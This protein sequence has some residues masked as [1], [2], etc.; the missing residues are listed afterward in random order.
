MDNGHDGAWPSILFIR[1][2]CLRT[3]FW[4]D[5]LRRVRVILDK[6]F[7]IYML[8]AMAGKKHY[9]LIKSD[10]ETLSFDEVKA[11]PNSTVDWNGVRNYQARNFMRDELK[12]GDQVLFYHSQCKDTGVVGLA[13]VVRESYPDHTAWDKKHRYYDPKTDKKNPTWYMVDLKWKK[14]FKQTVTLAEMKATPA[15]KEMRVVQRGQR[16]SVQPVTKKDFDRVCKMGMQ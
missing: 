10:P 11:R 4:R 16:L 14:V 2:M 9:W 3:I 12:K 1:R 6:Y 15:L 7:G 13:E 5:A 8:T